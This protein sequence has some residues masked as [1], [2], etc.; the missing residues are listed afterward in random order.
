MELFGSQEVSMSLEAFSLARLGGMLPLLGYLAFWDVKTRRVLKQGCAAV[1]LM[2]GLYFLSFAL[3]AI[4]A[5][6]SRLIVTALFYHGGGGVMAGVLFL[7]LA[8]LWGGIGGGDVKLMACMGAAL[9]FSAALETA[10]M[11]FLLSGI[12]AIGLVAGR[13]FFFAIKGIKKKPSGLSGSDKDRLTDREAKR[14]EE[15]VFRGSLPWIPFLFCG[16]ALL[17]LQKTLY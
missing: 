2:G 17:F 6:E 8:L 4:Q 12:W 15:S 5:G 11:G 16:A 1:A 10:L 3:P 13:I 7:T 14:T 9:G